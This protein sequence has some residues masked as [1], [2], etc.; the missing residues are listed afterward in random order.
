MNIEE[1]KNLINPDLDYKV[2]DGRLYFIDPPNNINASEE[3]ENLTDQKRW[4]NWRKANFEYFTNE[5]LGQDRGKIFIDLGA[6][7]GRF[8][9]LI[10]EF[11]NFLAVDFYPYHS[12]KV[13]ADFT[14][15]L[16]F[17]DNICDIVLLSNV[18]E[19]VPTPDLLIKE[20]YRILKPGGVL[21][22][23]VP[24]LVKVHQEPYDFLR[25]TNFML[26]HLLESSG[27]SQIGVKPLGQPIDLMETTLRRFFVMLNAAPLNRINR[28]M[29]R[30]SEKTAKC[31]LKI[32]RSVHKKA[33]TT[34]KF[35]EGYG[36]K[37]QK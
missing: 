11:E 1:L 4:S 32:F 33:V 16:P 27:F 14:K 15:P 31:F 20:C 23:A 6:G 17:K 21:I 25:Y 37:A 18:L 7:P 19:H 3:S 29:A 24:F 9:E 13:V 8:R 30:L 2:I 34:Y 5:L 12:V 28:F 22:G 26:N 10:N 36:F 35:T